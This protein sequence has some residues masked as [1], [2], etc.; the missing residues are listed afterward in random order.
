MTHQPHLIPVA[1]I[2]SAGA[3]IGAF[4]QLLPPVAAFIA[5]IWYCLEIYECKTV[6]G[7]LHNRRRRKRIRSAR[8]RRITHK[9]TPPPT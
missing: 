7:F 8:L 3:I 2:I 6:Q 9:K 5:I 4:A 1:D